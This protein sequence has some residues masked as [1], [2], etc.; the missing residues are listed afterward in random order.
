MGFTMST[1]VHNTNSNGIHWAYLGPDANQHRLMST[2]KFIQ[3]SGYAEHDADDEA[4]A[5][6]HRHQHGRPPK[7]CIPN[8]RRR[9]RLYHWIESVQLVISHSFYETHWLYMQPVEG[10]FN[11]YGSEGPRHMRWS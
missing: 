8:A 11:R 9:R 5:P 6:P 1:T 4:G 2:P 3:F 10:A 7:Y